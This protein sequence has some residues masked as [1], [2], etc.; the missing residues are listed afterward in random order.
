MAMQSVWCNK[1]AFPEIIVGEIADLCMRDNYVDI[2]ISD[3]GNDM[4]IS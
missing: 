1:T 3:K 4:D 2:E